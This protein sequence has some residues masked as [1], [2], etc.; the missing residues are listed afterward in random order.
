VSPEAGAPRSGDATRRIG[1]AADPRPGTRQG[2][3]KEAADVSPEAGAPRSGDA[4]R[5]I[6]AGTDT[7]PVAR[8]GGHEEAAAAGGC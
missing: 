3:H 2:G 7:H 4:T 1:A 8:Q 5:R 6:G